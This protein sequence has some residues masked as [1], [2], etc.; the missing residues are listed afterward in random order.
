MRGWKKAK[1]LQD[2]LNEHYRGEAR[3]CCIQSGVRQRVLDERPTKFFFSTVKG[4]QKRS[5]MECLDTEEGKVY[6][7]EGMLKTAVAF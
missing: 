7:V 5:S 6:S 4:R 2:V 1:V 3:K